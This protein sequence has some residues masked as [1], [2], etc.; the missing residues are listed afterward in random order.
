MKEGVHFVYDNIKSIDMGLVN[1][2]ISGG[3][4]EEAFLANRDISEISISGKD[5]PYFQEVRFSP[6]SFDLTFAF[7]YS[8]DERKVREVARWLN[9]RY[10]KPFYTVD[11]P[12]RVF[13]CM[14]VGDSSLIHNGLKQGYITLTMRCDSPYSYTRSYIN[15]NN[16]FLSTDLTKTIEVNTFNSGDGVSKNI[17]FSNINQIQLNSISTL[18]WSELFGK[19]WSEIF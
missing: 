13:Y 5:E 17:D 16:V 12:N 2:Q 11:N 3:M 4:F 18:S 8:Y 14:L 6:L 1:C 9:Q 19:K 7:E 15:N 10:Y